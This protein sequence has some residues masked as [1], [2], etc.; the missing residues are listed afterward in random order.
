VHS[1][2][3]TL[4][5]V[6]L[7]CLAFSAAVSAV[8]V[9]LRDRQEENRRLDRIRNVLSVAGLL[10]RGERPSREE[11]AQRFEANLEPRLV[12][13]ATGQYVDGADAMAFEQR[14][15]AAD[16]A[17]SRPAPENRAKVRRVP[18]RA[19]V[20]LLGSEGR[21][22]GVVLPV[23]GYGLWSTM[24]GYLALDADA[25]TIRG[26][27]FYEHGET[28][29][30]GGEVDNPRWKAL[31]PGRLAFDAE[32]EP[33]IAVAKGHAGPPSEDP[34]RV[35]GLSGATLT[36]NGVTHM[37]RFWLGEHA[38]GP[39]LEALRQRAGQAGRAGG[40]PG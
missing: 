2:R 28:A 16:P 15:A 4:V 39:Y 40:G 12:E 23:E 35:D 27:T 34:Y 22:A 1:I 26:L 38:F 24:Y 11:L 5:F 18:D 32:G 17:R 29:G 30:L 10:E 21:L 33:R 3:H 9:S 8:S 20:Y 31:W 14:R 7:L 13:L 25:R 19:L 6:L 37:L 36:S